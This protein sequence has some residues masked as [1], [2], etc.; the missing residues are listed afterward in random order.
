MIRTEANFERS[1]ANDKRPTT[2][3]R[4]T[5]DQGATLSTPTTQPAASDWDVHTH[6]DKELV[7]GLGLTSATM[8]V[9]GSMIGSGIFIVSAEIGREVGFTRFAD[10]SLGRRRVYDDCRRAHVWRIGGHDAAG[11]R[12]ICLSARI[13]RA[14]LGISLR[15]DLISRYSDRHDCCRGRGF[16]Q[17]S[18]RIRATRFPRRTGFG[19]SGKFRP[20]MSARWCSA[21]WMSASIRRI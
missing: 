18:G 11:R 8:L 10:R 7:Q 15:L 5:T 21:T 12:A 14:A 19:I 3:D 4:A 9:M 6:Q 13:A 16:R 2:N 1:I 20:F 17:V